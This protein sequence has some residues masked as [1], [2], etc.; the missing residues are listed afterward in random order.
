M[1]GII[2]PDNFV[3]IKMSLSYDLQ[4][5]LSLTLIIKTLSV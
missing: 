3:L 5:V 1:E 4:K 2:E